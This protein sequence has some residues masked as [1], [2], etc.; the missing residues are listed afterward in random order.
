MRYTNRQTSI[1]NQ[2]SPAQIPLDIPRVF[3]ENGIIAEHYD[4]YE[5]RSQQVEMAL[6]VQ[7]ALIENKLLAVEAGT[8]VGKSF[9][10]LVPAVDIAQR[11]SGRVLVSTYTIT[12][13]EQLIYKDIPFLQKAL[14]LSFSAVLAKGRAN[15]ICKRR[16][17]F[18]INKWRTLF[19]EWQTELDRLADWASQTKDGSLSDLDFL[20]SPQVWELVSSE[21]GNCPA[22]SCLH[23]KDCFYQKAR[24]K[25]ETADIII[26]NHSLLFSDLALRQQGFELLPDYKY[27]IIDEAHNIEH[28]AEDHFGIDISSFRIKRL[29]NEL[30]NPARHKGFL[31]FVAGQNAVDAVF[32]ASSASDYFFRNINSWFQD[33]YEQLN[34]RCYANFVDDTLSEHLKNLRSRLTSLANQT[35]D[36]DNKFELL[37]FAGRCADLVIELNCFLSQSKTGFVYWVE[38]S[39]E[40]K[41]IIHLRSAPLNVSADVKA[42]LFDKFPSVILTSA[43]LSCENSADK[44]GFIFF[45]GR[46]GL[47]NFQA[48]KLGSPFDFK[49][50]VTI[51]IEKDIPDPNDDRFIDTAAEKVKKYLLKTA[52]RAFLLFTSYQML[53]QMADVLSGWLKEND[54][55]LLAQG[56]GR[57]RTTLLKYFRQSPKNKGKSKTTGKKVLF[58]TDSFWQGV[59]VP[60]QALSNVIIVRLPFAVPD[61]PLIAGRIE[62]IRNDG[63]N[64]FND[65]QLPFAIIKFKQGFGRLIRTKTDT[66][67]IVILDSRIV[68]RPYGKK[69]L[70]SIP[71][72]NIQLVPGS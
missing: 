20:P 16:L 43:T 46:I 4:N 13:Q 24:R 48:L 21:H 49:N 69:F 27:V 29:L 68:N 6:A 22:R 30:Y 38:T 17:N 58:G 67:I 31:S 53:E 36:T 42:A 56:R 60:G 59:D 61:K 55:E 15:Y 54:M 65:Y 33:N 9:A 14:D 7:K 51:Y 47:D 52:G 44:T 25:I 2:Q 5:F 57:D 11:K 12:L 18:A 50:N 35:D 62:Q 45:A 63:G 32:K 37:R 23:Y 40:P 41:K 71:Q 19:N 70:D 10:Y 28:V 8:G 72:C 1:H 26:A 39:K 66:G 3:S 34:G 64:P